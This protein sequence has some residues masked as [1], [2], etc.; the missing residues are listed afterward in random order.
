[1]AL[2]GL[3][4]PSSAVAACKQFVTFVPGEAEA[5]LQR[6]RPTLEAKSANAT[7]QLAAS[8]DH[9]Q[10]TTLV[11]HMMQPVASRYTC[12]FTCDGSH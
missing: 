7:G 5:A 4:V 3:G 11:R 9:L 2:S 10:V 1:M 6:V 8:L 12:A